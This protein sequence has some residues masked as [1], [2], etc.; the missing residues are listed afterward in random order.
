MPS[1]LLSR[2]E[3]S[4]AYSSCGLQMRT[5]APIKLRRIGLDPTRDR[6]VIHTQSPFQHDFFEI[7]VAERIAQIPANAQQKNVG[8]EVAPFERIL[9]VVAHNGDL[10]R[11]LLSTVADQLFLCN[12]TPIRTS[13]LEG[14]SRW[15]FS[16]GQEMKAFRL[17]F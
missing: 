5:T 14:A 7:S 17:S 11:S 2:R 4:R 10:F 8:L 12:T 3:E 9:A 6:G 15:F 16:G 13:R 1:T